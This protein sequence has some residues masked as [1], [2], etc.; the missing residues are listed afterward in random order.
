M[1]RSV[2]LFFGR[3]AFTGLFLRFPWVVRAILWIVLSRCGRHPKHSW[4]SLPQAKPRTWTS[5]ARGRG[6]M[7][8]G[9][10]SPAPSERNPDG[11]CASTAASPNLQGHLLASSTPSTAHCEGSPDPISH[12]FV[13]YR[14]PGFDRLCP[15]KLLGLGAQQTWPLANAEDRGNKS[16]NTPAS[17]T[18]EIQGSS[19]K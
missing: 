17:E 14:N 5:W 9:G 7:G 8:T 18:T 13:Q 15:K 11:R 6:S 10:L 4:P 16:G 1:V 2:L 12:A 19:R 3:E